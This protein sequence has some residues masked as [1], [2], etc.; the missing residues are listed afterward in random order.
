MCLFM[1][2]NVQYRISGLNQ[3]KYNSHFAGMSLPPM[4]NDQVH[5]DD[6]H[7]EE[8]KQ[9][10]DNLLSQYHGLEEHLRGTDGTLAGHMDPASFG[11]HGSHHLHTGY[12]C[13]LIKLLL[14]A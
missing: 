12:D 9:H 13:M 8:Y 2:F 7:E 4:I 14:Q 10:I 5:V 1:S 11:H 6:S 3:F